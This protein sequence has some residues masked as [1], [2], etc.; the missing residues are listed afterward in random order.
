M[1]SLDESPM[2]GAVSSTA[3]SELEALCFEVVDSDASCVGAAGSAAAVAGFELF[4]VVEL[5]VGAA[6][7]SVASSTAER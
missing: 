6:V 1:S 7:W 2:R 3:G 4:A 5:A